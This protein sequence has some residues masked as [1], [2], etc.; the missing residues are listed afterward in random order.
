MMSQRS[1]RLDPLAVEEPLSAYPVQREPIRLYEGLRLTPSWQ[2]I[3]PEAFGYVLMRGNRVLPLPFEAQPIL[4][5]CN[6]QT[7]LRDIQTRLGQN[8][9]E[10]VVE[11]AM[12]G[13]IRLTSGDQ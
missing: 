10:M 6:G 5:A 9:V 12:Q 13:L 3:R 2:R 1:I 11:L 4:E 8:G 7:T